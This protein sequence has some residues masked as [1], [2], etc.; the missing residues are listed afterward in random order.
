VT[1]L[2]ATCI[3]AATTARSSSW[4]FAQNF[5]QNDGWWASVRRAI[6]ARSGQRRGL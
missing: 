1:A 4:D 5:A 6:G 3:V 2:L